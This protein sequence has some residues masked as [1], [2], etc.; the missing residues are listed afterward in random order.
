MKIEIGEIQIK[1]I[2]DVL[3]DVADLAKQRWNPDADKMLYSDRSAIER[4]Q[5]IF[6]T[7]VDNAKK[8]KERKENE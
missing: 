1:L 5:E 2:Q 6:N 8:E 3:K 7:A 4:V